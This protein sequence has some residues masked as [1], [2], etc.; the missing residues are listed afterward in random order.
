MNEERLF[1][2][3]KREVDVLGRAL[4]KAIRTLSG[5]R[6]FE[7]EEQVREL[8]KSLR[9]GYSPEARQQLLEIVRGLSLSEAENVIRAF[10]TYFHLVNL[11]EERHR[12]RVNR[13]REKNSTLGAPRGESFLALVG[14]LKQQGLDY[15]QTVDL[16]SRLR[17]H[18]TFTAHP[19]ETRR[20]TQ[21]HHIH[22][23]EKLLDSL[24]L[25]D[26]T[27][28]ADSS[29]L[30]ARVALL[31]GTS[32][33]R[34]SRPSVEDEV[35]GGLFY[36]TS[37]LW[38]AVPRLVDGLERAVEAHYGQRPN[39]SP[40]LVFR[41]WIGGD[42]DGNPNVL[43]AVTSWAQT[44]ARETAL[45]RFVEDVDALIR[46]LSLSDERVTITHELRL[47]LEDH[48][49]RLALPERFQGE[50]Y[51]QFGMGLRYKLR[52]LLGEQPGPGYSSTG[53][54][55]GDLGKAERSL[56]QLG[57]REI[58]RA[59]LKPIRLNAEAFGLDLVSLDLREESR[60]L[61]EAAAELLKIGGV[62]EQ[63]AA[64]P[65]QQ[66]EA[67]LT[68]ELATAR[69]LAP[70]GYRPQSK[71]LQTALEALRNWK[72]R[73]AHVV[74][75][76][77][78]PS[79]LLEVMLLAREVGLF[80]PG[81]AL[82][83]DVVPLFETLDDLQN[84]PEVVARL[85]DNPVFRAH[86]QGRGGLE[87][88]IG[89]SDSNKDAGFLA[90]NWA[91]YRA[92]EA[93]TRVAQERGVTVYYFH[94][95]GTSTARGGGTAGRAIASL[96]PGTVGSRMRLTEQGEA[97]ADRYAHPELAYRNLEQML[98]H[99]ALASARD[100]YG[101]ARPLKPEWLEAMERAAERSTQVYRELLLRPGFFEFYEQLTPIREIGALN[102][103]SRPVYRSGRVRE[104]K[105]LRAIPWVM[106]WTQ[107]RLLLPG[108]YGLAEGLQEIPLA[109]RQEMFEQWP[110]FATTLDSAAIAL[111]K[112]DLG[113]AREYLRLVKPELAERFFPDIARSFEQTKAILEETFQNTLLFKHPV[114]ARQT[115][116]RNPYVD[117]ISLVQVELL[118]RYRRTPPEAPERTG[119]ERALMLSLLG[120]AAGLRNAG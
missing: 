113:I 79:D 96:P 46:D 17:L 31:W 95:R 47:A 44:Y 14:T 43:P 39:L 101:Q 25:D 63:Y 48:A 83:F 3:L 112:A 78:Y 72:A 74:S 30:D 26:L 8:T 108:W 66:R 107:V 54:F 119:L 49:K 53:E 41:S 4:G 15:E 62:H 58:A 42:R 115:E 2:Q 1:E 9:Q 105:D 24:Y 40:P 51:R 114:L 61:T 120:I 86:V 68:Q 81:R 65:P 18:L 38:K 11:A 104:I 103:A 16:L 36:I 34:K 64:L 82:P 94:G 19:T 111:A 27:T 70:V 88:M 89:Y 13:E 35:K 91:L 28:A 110:F 20:R 106:S 12:V 60:A 90:A 97:L 118:E 117:P 100:L 5:P 116:L 57:L 84:A 109:L 7:L 85:L 50:P 92:Q 69:P 87:V 98:Y 6:I 59:C 23:I 102:I 55:V 32:E 52:A 77:H 56:E 71:S 99:M 75:M 67:L 80:R 10:S 73:G 37:T 33:L 22:E 21:R 29:A 45:R 93:I 76:T